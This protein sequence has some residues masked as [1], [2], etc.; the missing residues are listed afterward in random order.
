[1][2]AFWTP[3]KCTGPYFLTSISAVFDGDRI[4]MVTGILTVLL[5]EGKVRHSL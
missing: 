4:P 3:Q 5:S 1:M 2:I